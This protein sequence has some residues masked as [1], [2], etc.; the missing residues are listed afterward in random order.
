[1]KVAFHCTKRAAGDV[2]RP[3]FGE[4]MAADQGLQFFCGWSR[5][6]LRVA[7]AIWPP[8]KC[9]SKLSLPQSV[10]IAESK[11]SLSME[12]SCSTSG[13]ISNTLPVLPV[14]A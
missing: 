6:P 5:L 1:V 13:P 4:V 2:T 8:F 14:A 12:P 10:Y 9:A 3:P 7:M 11:T